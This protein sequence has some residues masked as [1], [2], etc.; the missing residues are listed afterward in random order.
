M[1]MVNYDAMK[2]ASNSN[3]Q[4]AT[5][6]QLRVEKLKFLGWSGL[7]FHISYQKEL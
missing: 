2:S 3:F 6:W 7:Q 4:R 5:S 1:K